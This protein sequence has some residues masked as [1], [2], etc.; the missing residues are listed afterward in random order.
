MEYTKDFL[1]RVPYLGDLIADE[2]ESHLLDTLTGLLSRK[3]ILAYVQKL[4]EEKIPFTFGMIDLDNF[5]YINDTYGHKVG[6][7]VLQ[8]VA[9]NLRTF[10]SDG[11]VAGRF[12]GDEY[13]FVDRRHLMYDEKKMLLEKMYTTYSV[14]RRTI[15]MTD[16][17]VFIT[18]TTGC[19]TYPS[20]ADNYDNIFSLIDKTLYR[21]KKKGR[22][23]YI[24]YVEEKHKDI[25]I[26]ELAGHGLYQTFREL[27]TAF[28]SSPLVNKKLTAMLDVLK[29]DMRITDL[30]YVND[31]YRMKSVT[32]GEDLGAV[33]DIENLISEDLCTSN[34]I[35]NVQSLSPVLFATFSRNS[36][37][38]FLIVKMRI[39]D[40]NMG[41]LICAEPHNQRIWQDDECAILFSVGRML[42]GY[43]IGFG[44]TFE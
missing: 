10:L 5:K 18:A 34:N 37:E 39:L 29:E 19:A 14:L 31:W 2:E 1:M 40:R 24:I 28:D 26:E 4:I 42:A 36:F 17:E 43:M 12:G 13:L 35:E 9:G 27:A 38:T 20:D 7:Q 25:V 44:F 33:D 11:G 3:V 22:N 32:T 15:K 8:G 30:F 16:L 41:Y 23:C 6:D 21:G